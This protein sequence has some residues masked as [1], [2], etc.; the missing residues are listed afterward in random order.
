MMVVSLILQQRKMG[1][2]KHEGLVGRQGNQ[3]PS[4]AT[5]HS[6]EL[7]QGLLCPPLHVLAPL[8]IVHI[9]RSLYA[10]DGV[11]MVF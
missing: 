5:A 9:K 10:I 6:V 1:K 2:R 7:S 8:M 4:A 3:L 11:V